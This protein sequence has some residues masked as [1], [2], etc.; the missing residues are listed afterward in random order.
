M[1][2]LVTEAFADDIV[3]EFLP[4]TPNN[5]SAV[6]IEES[7]ILIL[8]KEDFIEFAE[9]YPSIKTNFEENSAK[10]IEEKNNL[11]KPFFDGISG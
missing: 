6:V 2:M 5:F 3:G 11:L 9:K 1:E 10:R 7:E 8:D 4:D